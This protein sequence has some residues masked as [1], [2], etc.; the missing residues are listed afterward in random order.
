MWQHWNKVLHKELDNQVLILEA[1]LNIQV[2]ELYSLGLGAFALSMALM[3]LCLPVL[4]HLP[5]AHIAHWLDT[6]QIAKEH[7][8]KMK[9]RPYRQEH[10]YMQMWLVRD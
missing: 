7:K 1:K 10:Q 6:A 4:P 3:K 8:A 5:Q 9:A 2:S